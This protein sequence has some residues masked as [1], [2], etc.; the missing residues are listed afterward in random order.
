[1]SE[2][3]TQNHEVIIRLAIA[4]GLGL[5][6][7]GER[8]WMHKQAGM[9]THALVSLGSAVF[10]IISEMIAIKYGAAAGFDPSRVASQ[11]IVGIGFL[12]AGSIIL[13]GNRL[14]GLTTAG[15]L[16]VTAGIGMAAGFGFHSLAVITT[17]LVLLVLI[18]VNFL[19]KPIRKISSGIDKP[20]VS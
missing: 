15:G 19:E 3:F 5:L 20:D 13:Q 11:I 8:L 12:G 4:V 9:K 16:W 6:I 17:V 14:L 10:V 2:F 1:M 7:G 18:V